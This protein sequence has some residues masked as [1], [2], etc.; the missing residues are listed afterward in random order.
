MAAIA[1]TVIGGA[2][3]CSENTDPKFKPC[4]ID[5]SAFTIY[6]PT[7]QDLYYEL[8]EDGTFELI[9][10]GQPT[11]GFSAVTQYRA[12]VSL[13]EDGFDNPATYR[14]L[15]PT[16]TGTLS[17]MTLNDVDLAVAINE[18]HGVEDKDDY[19]DRG[20]EKVYL[21]GYAYIENVPESEVVTANTTSLNKV[22][23]FFVLQKPGIIYVIGNYAGGWIAPI[24]DN[25]A[26][27]EAYTLKENDNEIRSK[28]YHGTINF[29]PALVPT[30]GA[31]FRF[32]PTL[33]GWDAKFSVGCS[34]GPEGD[35]PVDF[36]DFTAG[37]TLEH[38]I[39]EKCQNSFKFNNYRGPIIM[40]VNMNTMKAIFEAPAQ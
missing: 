31:I 32:Y 14:T 37:T 2:T 27:L 21:R 40:T 29:D 13:T 7:L 30:E 8:T 12:L 24:Q 38:G 22:Q 15:T 25:A 36:P 39:K 11:Y 6:T 34:G 20:P 17:R 4:N 23:N 9:L 35:V 5:P 19:I 28:I 3:S 1:A 18:L 33:D 16:G 26:T 10:S